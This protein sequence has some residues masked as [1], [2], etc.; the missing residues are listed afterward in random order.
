MKDPPKMDLPVWY[1]SVAPVA[2]V[3][4]QQDP[5][6]QGDN[7]EP[8]WSILCCVYAWYVGFGWMTTVS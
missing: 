4:F 6:E 1:S 3:V 5:G 7:I 2:P 8:D